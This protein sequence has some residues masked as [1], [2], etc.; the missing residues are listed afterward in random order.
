MS[1]IETLLIASCFTL[2]Y[3]IFRGTNDQKA[4]FKKNPNK[5]I[6]GKKPETIDSP[7][8]RKLLVSGWW[9]IA[10]KINYLGDILIA[11][12]MTAASGYTFV[13]PHLYPIYL[14]LLLIDR[15][16]R[17][18]ARCQVKHKE[19]WTEYCNR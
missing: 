13:V 11:I 14:T 9:G 2:G 17:D 10:R 1:I 18:N 5:P 6:W 12:S 8:G 3:I 7:A 15:A 4:Q 16:R 19:A